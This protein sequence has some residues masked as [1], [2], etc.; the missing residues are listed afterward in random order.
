MATLVVPA[1]YTLTSTEVWVDPSSLSTPDPELAEEAAIAATWALWTMSGERFHG[2]QCWVEDYRTIKGY[3]NIQ[4]RQW[5]VGEVLEV[6][7]IDMCDNTVGATGVGTVITGWCDLGGGEIRVCNNSS[8]NYGFTGCG[9]SSNETV[10]RVHYKTTNNLPPGSDRAVYR[11]AEEYVK[12]YLGQA[13]S[14]PERVTSITRQGASWTLLDPQ[15]F[16]QDGLTGVGPVDQ[17]LAQVGLR[18]RWVTLTD[19]LR[20]VPRVASVLIDC[21]DNA[22]F[23]GGVSSAYPSDSLFPSGDTY[24]G[25]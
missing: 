3:C 17:W 18:S 10:V 23:S 24:P 22:Y 9:S 19:P 25:V 11:L 13:C 21:G 15:D 8:E 20:S 7:T 1:A 16:L 12:C 2:D 5:P 14:L 4:L 6:S